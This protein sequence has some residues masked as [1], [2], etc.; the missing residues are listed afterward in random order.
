MESPQ[1]VS[2]RCRTVDNDKV[3]SGLLLTVDFQSRDTKM[4][5]T[6]QWEMTEVYH[7]LRNPPLASGIFIYLEITR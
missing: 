2:S 3:A 5:L 7:L 6:V 4:V 1:P